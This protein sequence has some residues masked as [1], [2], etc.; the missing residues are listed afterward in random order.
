MRLF[1][2]LLMACWAN[3]TAQLP[4]ADWDFEQPYRD[5]MLYLHALVN[6]SYDL[7]WQLDWERRQLGDNALRVNTGS[8][9]SDKLLS[10]I[11]LNINETLNAKWRFQG[12]FRRDGLRQRPVRK[13]QLLLGFERSVF[14]SSALYVT[15][16][17]EFNKE[18]LDVAA[19]YTLYRD[20]RQ[21]YVRV[22]VLLED[23][24]YETKNDV[25]GISEQDN[26][27]LQW[28][29]RLGLAKDWFLYS[30]GE[31]GSGFERVFADASASPEVSRHEQRV[32]KAQVRL[33]RASE[34]GTLWSAW[35]DWQ[36]FD[37]A[38][39][40]R[41]PGFDFDYE[42]TQLD[43]AVEHARVFRDRHRLRLLLHYVELEA[44]SRGFNEH[45]YERKEVLGGAFYEYLWP[46]SG[47]TLAYAFG[48]PDI[49]YLAL[50]PA[51]NYKLDD[52][53]DK[54]IVGWR[55]NFSKNA[56]IDLS[57]SHEVSVQGFGGGAV[58]FQMF[59]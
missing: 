32:N 12:S 26:V 34:N 16:N 29:I 19:G 57:I 25:G 27:A 36:S 37:D 7:Q 52:Y 15:V 46:N 18:F 53:R 55:Y 50:D 20:E 28:A 31:V 22:G 47:A 33:S 30:E 2:L 49:D 1:L 11:D 21:Q 3:A 56:Q 42:N 51:G 13:E 8:V 10:D 40:F 24:N 39:Q 14:E 45:D 4:D 38:R 59:F 35:V 41:Q 9:T 23:M 5:Q 48:Q 17:P 6:Y 43:I 44:S 58:R 54:L